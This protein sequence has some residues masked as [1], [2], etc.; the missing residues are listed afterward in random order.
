MNKGEIIKIDSINPE[1]EKIKIAAGIIKSSGLVAFPT[2]TV[3]GLGANAL[4]ERA[5]S[6]IFEVKRRPA[7]SPLILFIYKKED[8]RNFVEEVPAQADL[9]IERFWPGALTLVFKKSGI[10]SEPLTCGSAKIGIRIP[11]NKVVLSL[12]KEIDVPL[13]TTS[14]NIH[15]NPSPTEAHEVLHDL[16]GKIDLILDGGKTTLG[17]ESTVLDVTTLPPIILREGSISKRELE[18]VLGNKF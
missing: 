6:K 11:N 16:E 9:L 8:L 3:Y 5:V 15:G 14:A 10:L 18:K 7:Y 13:A 17:I 2:D 4:N 1:L 12:I